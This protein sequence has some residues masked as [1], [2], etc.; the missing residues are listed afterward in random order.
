MVFGCSADFVSAAVIA[1]ISRVL[2]GYDG[3]GVFRFVQRCSVGLNGVGGLVGRLVGSGEWLEEEFAAG[4]VEADRNLRRAA[5]LCGEAGGM[6]LDGALDAS[7]ALGEEVHH[8]LL[9]AVR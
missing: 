5:D 2:L 3:V 4:G 7:P 8:A 6:L 9:F 1:L